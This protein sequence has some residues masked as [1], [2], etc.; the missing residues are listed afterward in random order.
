M[1][2]ETT[3]TAVKWGR[4]TTAVQAAGLLSAAAETMLER[5]G[6][7]R[8]SDALYARV[9]ACLFPDGV[10]LK[11]QHDQHRFHI[12]MLLVVKLTRY[13]RNWEHGHTDSLTD[14]INYGAMLQALDQGLGEVRPE[15]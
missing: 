4:P 15:G 7:Y 6:R 3:S 1:T 10:E 5:D 2:D 14:L 12:F 8:G 13:V 11:S 9:M